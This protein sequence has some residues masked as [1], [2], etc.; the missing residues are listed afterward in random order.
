MGSKSGYSVAPSRGP[1]LPRTLRRRCRPLALFNAE[2]HLL[3]RL[4]LRRHLVIPRLFALY[5]AARRCPIT[6]SIHP[7]WSTSAALSTRCA[8]TPSP[9]QAADQPLPASRASEHLLTPPSRC[10]CLFHPR[11]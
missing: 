6:C 8:P 10:P 2:Y 1:V 4:L 9:P 3:G 11:R 7:P 5:D